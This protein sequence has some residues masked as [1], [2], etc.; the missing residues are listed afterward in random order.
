VRRAVHVA[1]L[2]FKQ[3]KHV[4]FNTVDAEQPLRVH[5]EKSG[6]HQ[7]KMSPFAV[8]GAPNSIVEN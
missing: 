2:A 1:N 5:V 7:L 8:I 3:F 6:G 4:R